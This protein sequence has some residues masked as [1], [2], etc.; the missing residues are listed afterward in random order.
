MKTISIKDAQRLSGP[1]PFALL[2]TADAQG[3]P[4]IMAISWWTYASNNPPALIVCLGE[5][6]YSSELIQ[7]GNEFTL[8]VVGSGMKGAGFAC[9]TCSG[10]TVDKAEKFSVALADS[11]IVRPPYVRDSR[12]V[13]ECRVTAQAEAGNHTAFIASVVAAHGDETTDQLFA[14][15]G[16]ARL[17]TLA[18]T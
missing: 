14:L 15:D 5:N 11:Q 4:N 2:V 16:Y 8:C 7:S 12:I 10:R 18:Q 3:K 1:Q 6:S 17:G 9:G 13:L